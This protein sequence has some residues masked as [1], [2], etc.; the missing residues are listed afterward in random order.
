MRGLITS[1]CIVVAGLIGSSPSFAQLQH[2]VCMDNPGGT[3]SCLYDSFA[4]CQ[5][6]TTS[7]SVG[8]S[9]IANPAVTGPSTTGQGG[10][11]PL[12]TVPPPT[13]APPLR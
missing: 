7:R 3:I 10:I 11:A 4:Q 2:P 13:V 8:T 5:Q 9:C 1:S 6:A 12:P